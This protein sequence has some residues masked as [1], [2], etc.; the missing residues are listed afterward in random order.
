MFEYKDMFLTYKEADNSSQSTLLKYDG[1]LTRF[2][3]FLVEKGVTD[4]RQVQTMHMDMYQAHLYKTNKPGTISNKQS[5]LSSFFR[6]MCDREYI[7]ENENP[8]RKIKRV[9]VKDSDKKKKESLTVD[10]ALR[11][12]KRIEEVSSPS[13][14]NRNKVIV[15]SFLFFG[16]RVSELCNLK[17]EDIAIKE[18]TL[19][20]RGGKGGKNRE[21]PLF[22]EL[23]PELKMHMK[24]KKNDGYL[25]TRNGSDKPLTQR[26][27]RNVVYLARKKA[28]IKKNIA[29]HSLRVT[30]ATL[31]LEA[32]VDIKKIQVFLGHSSITTTQLYLHTDIEQMKQEIKKKSLLSK[33]MKQNGK[34]KKGSTNENPNS[35]K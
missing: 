16:L 3:N 15:L 31:L 7:H 23:I 20:I 24:T 32:G 34:K 11:M 12:I 2:L 5:I 10:E 1:E 8:M 4:I 9:K 26:A 35:V 30:A 18:E 14:K 25:F 29:C 13:L 22:D 33:E 17:V 27:V 6:F 21:I 28:R 19:Y